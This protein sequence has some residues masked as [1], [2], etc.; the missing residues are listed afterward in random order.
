MGTYR[1]FGRGPIAGLD[2]LDDDV[3]PSDDWLADLHADLDGLLDEVGASQGRIVV[4]LPTDRRPTDW[5]RNVHGLERARWATADMAYRRTALSAVGG[6]D[7][8]FRRAYRED[9]DL[10]LRVRA[11]GWR[12]IRGHRVVEHPVRP[13]DR[14]VQRA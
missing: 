2:R 7:E 6:F 5:E 13:A 10:A 9:A 14:W 1:F 11:A 8:R 4:P 3:V 12:L